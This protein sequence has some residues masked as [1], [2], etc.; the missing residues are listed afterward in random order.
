MYEE[1]ETG[2]EKG[3]ENPVDKLMADLNIT[4]LR[5]NAVIRSIVEQAVLKND[6]AGAIKRLT[7]HEASENIGVSFPAVGESQ[8]LLGY[9]QRL[10]YHAEKPV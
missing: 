7:S 3:P 1:F 8:R 9:F 5:D 6:P 4:I 10:M 2:L